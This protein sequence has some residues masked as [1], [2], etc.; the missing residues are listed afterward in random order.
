MEESKKT[1]AI[2]LNRQAYREDDSLVTVYTPDLGKLNLVARGTKKLQSKLAGH[3]EPLTLAD[4]MIIPGR[5]FDYIGSAVS[6]EI[7]LGIREDLNKLYYAGQ[8]VRI[9]NRLVKEGDVETRLFFLL[10]DWLENLNNF[11]EFK[12]ENG[13]LLWI[14][15]IWQFLAEL[16]YKPEMYKCLIC[17]EEIKPGQSYFN[18]AKGGVV[19]QSCF[20]RE[21]SSTSFMETDI[22]PISDNCVKMVRFILIGKFS[23]AE[24]TRI[25]K[26]LIR[27]LSGLADGFVKY[28]F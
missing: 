7:Y 12:K 9:F 23:Q 6:R 27:E 8:V 1:S 18:L 3:I 11:A 4:I 22:L 25:D 14:F 19:C 2:I 21:R 28:C 17:N 5:G 15:F 26:K 16:G 24:K 13:E 10:A 20:E